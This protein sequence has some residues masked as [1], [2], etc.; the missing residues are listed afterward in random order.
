[1]I[2]TILFDLDDTLLGNDMDIFL[3]HYFALLDKYAAK[4][5]DVV[6]FVPSV[7]KASEF[8]TRNTDPALT[9]NEVFWQ[10][11]NGLIGLDFVETRAIFDNF[12]RGEFNQ[13]QGI[14]KTI[15][16]RLQSRHCYQSHVPTR[17]G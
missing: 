7:L 12:Y 17:G 6:D 4:H 15:P 8:M 9:N 13:L 14:T 16:E 5:L 3:P 2:K 11:I 10:E 1:M